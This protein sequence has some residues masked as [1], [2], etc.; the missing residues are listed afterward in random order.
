MLGQR[1]LQVMGFGATAVV[2]A[3][4]VRCGSSDSPPASGGGGT[5]SAGTGG[6]SSTGGSSG[7]VGGSSISDSSAGGGSLSDVNPDAYDPSCST[8]PTAFCTAGTAPR[9]LISDFSVPDGGALTTGCDGTTFTSAYGL[10]G[11]EYY[12]GTYVYPTSCTDACLHSSTP[13]VTPLLQD[14]SAGNWHI[15][16]SV[17]NY[18]GFGVYMSHR[19]APID[20]LSGTAPYQG[21][22]Y[23]VMDASAYSGVKFTISGNAGTPSVVGIT[24]Q[25]AA[26]VVGTAS[27]TNDLH[28]VAQ[29]V[30]TCGTCPVAPCG[31]TEL[32]IPVTATPTPVTITWAQA[33]IPDPQAF[34][35]VSGRFI[36]TTTTATFPVDVTI[37]DIT[38]T[39]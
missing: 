31:N 21:P 37:D 12:G 19:T 1:T 29:T 4:A 27:Y 23:A 6:S 10:Y 38:F 7:G 3:F 9:A 36:W 13:S 33:G 25:S 32:M 15:T 20:P 30:N 26:T 34:M 2:V 35:N 22:P 16:G 11:D 28:P 39:P 18:S 14:L 17:G 8:P 5:S 24:L